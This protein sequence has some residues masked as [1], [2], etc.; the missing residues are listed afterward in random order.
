V[1]CGLPHV[2]GPEYI[3][4]F[5]NHIPGSRINEILGG[6]LDQVGVVI[7]PI[8]HRMATAGVVGI[9]SASSQVRNLDDEKSREASDV[10]LHFW[11]SMCGMLDTVAES[12]LLL[13]R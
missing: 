1:F 11:L 6:F 2:R 8:T 5:L 10:N 7:P 3:R 12:T 4:V 9:P 13:L